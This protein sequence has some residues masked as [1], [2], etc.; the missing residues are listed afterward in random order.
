LPEKA[1]LLLLSAA[2]AAV[3]FI[4][5]RRGGAVRTFDLYP[6]AVRLENGVVSIVRYLG[7]MA[8][9]ADLAIWYP[10]PRGALPPVTVAAAALFVAAITLAAVRSARKA[11]PLAVGWFWYLATLAPVLG[12]V[13]VGGQAMADRYTYIP[14]VGV[15]L[16]ICF[17][18]AQVAGS[19]RSIAPALAAVVVVALAA[20]AVST[21]GQIA[22]WRDNI[23]LF[24]RAVAVTRDNWQ[25]HI[26]LATSLAKAGRTDEA[27]SHFAEVERLRPR[28][29]DSHRLAAPGMPAGMPGRD[30][31]PGLMTA[32]LLAAQGKVDQAA[33]A[34][35]SVLAERPDAIDARREL[36]DVLINGGRPA[37]ALRQYD[38]LVAAGEGGRQVHNNR[39]VALVTLGRRDE[40]IEAFR[41]GVAA[42]PASADARINLAKAL[43]AA[44]RTGEGMAELRGVLAAEPGNAQARWLLED[45]GR[46]DVRA[47]P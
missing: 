25:A 26:N 38:L 31:G 41:L 10:H 42:D 32:R 8:W 21:A 11:P 47:K 22:H 28:F 46:A 14:S 37:E 33:A 2:S 17:G 43:V 23:A 5:Q 9:P 20:S 4:V 6:P 13:Q 30:A 45:A 16:A 19:R 3:T 36:A 15:T 40:A 1:P 39:G 18:A 24:E 44:G 29:A 27:A 35:E 12:I 34:Y 7:K